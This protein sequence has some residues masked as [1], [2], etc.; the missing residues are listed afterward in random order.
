MV[1]AARQ[2]NPSLTCSRVPGGGRRRPFIWF[3][4]PLAC[5]RR[6][7]LKVN[8]DSANSTWTLAGQ[9]GD[10]LLRKPVEGKTGRKHSLSLV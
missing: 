1:A 3:V 4:W 8:H 10:H 2:V 9:V 7:D 5:G 6:R